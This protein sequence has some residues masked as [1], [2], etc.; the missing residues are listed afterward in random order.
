MKP[1]ISIIVCTYNRCQSLRDTLI[2]L[3]KQR[4]SDDVSV[5]LIVIDN[6]STDSTRVV[7]ESEAKNSP[8]SIRYVFEA[9]QGISAARNRGIWEATGELIEFTD[10]DTIP[11][12]NW[13][14]SLWKAY[15]K[16]D[17]DFLGGKID[18]LW[19]TKPPNWLVNNRVLL[20]H[21]GIIDHD[22]TTV[23][24]SDQFD[25][26]L[27][28]GAN[29]AFRR[30]CFDKV[31]VFRN[32]LGMK[33]GELLRGE[34]TEIVERFVA[35]GKKVIYVPEAVVSHKVEPYRTKLSYFRRLRFGSGRT[36]EQMKPL[37]KHSLPF[38]LWRE[39]I[40]NGLSALWSYIKRL[41]E[42]GIKQE[43][44]FWFQLGVITEHIR[45]KFYSLK[46]VDA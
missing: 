19:L 9:T 10:D 16:Y 12:E 5:E 46:G 18:L 40:Q 41:Q 44:I 35:A 14:Q 23:F 37:S 25:T 17:A 29:M 45:Q 36:H 20:G 3:K 15:K 1:S 11:N 26:N 7:V 2:A 8:F 43:M 6:N 32:D 30:S 34:D 22:S 42:E 27:V 31:G 33:G 28:Y 38:W 21:L 4:F 39:C 13:G 24:S